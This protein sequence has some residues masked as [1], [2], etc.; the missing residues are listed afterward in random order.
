MFLMLS[1]LRKLQGFRSSVPGTGAETCT[2][3]CVYTFFFFCYLT[4]FLTIFLIFYWPPFY[5]GREDIFIFQELLSSL[6][7]FK[8]SSQFLFRRSNITFSSQRTRCRERKKTSK[9]GA[10]RL[11]SQYARFHTVLSLSTWGL[12]TATFRARC[13]WFSFSGEYPS[14]ILSGLGEL[15]PEF[16]GWEQA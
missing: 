2:R 3:M 16:S 5:G 12:T 9:K 7:L 11:T 6:L 14:D 8:N 4:H 15:V 1:S 10:Q 13:A